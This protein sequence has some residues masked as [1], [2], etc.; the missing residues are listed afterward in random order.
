MEY[1][2]V[3]DQIFHKPVFILLM[4]LSFFLVPDWV[5]RFF[6]VHDTKTGKSTK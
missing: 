6:L 4:N 5:A 3:Q 2:R 1:E